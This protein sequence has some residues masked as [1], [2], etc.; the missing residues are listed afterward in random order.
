MTLTGRLSAFFLGTLALV[1]VG[2]SLTLYG[3]AR[4]YLTRQ[5]EDQLESTLDILAGA[6]EVGPDGVEW[7]PHEGQLTLGRDDGAGQV[8]WAVLDLYGEPVGRLGRSQNLHGGHL[9]PGGGPS[10]GMSAGSDQVVT[11]EASRWRVVQRTITASG[12][13][14]SLLDASN[15]KLLEDFDRRCRRKDRYAVLILTSA[16]CLDPVQDTLNTLALVLGGL[17]TGLWLLAAL[18][19]RWLCR[20]AL[21]PLTRMATAARA[22]GAAD[23][24]QR[25]PTP[26]TADELQDLG[27]AFN[28]LLARLHEAFERQRRFTGDASHQLRTPLTAMLGQVEVALRRGR[29]PDEYRQVLGLTT[30]AATGPATPERPTCASSGPPALGYWFGFSR[31]CSASS[32]TTSWRTPGNTA[33]PAPAWPCGLRL[34]PRPSR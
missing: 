10:A 1:L 19:G 16:V 14:S 29:S 7:E 24:D 9:L 13:S 25:L 28:D 26:A 17:S 11:Q 20:R 34:A 8:R 5:V 22:M 33:L 31:P 3:L 2:F 18:L 27:Q 15:R 21:V 4:V 23:R 32:W 6:A 30:T 12:M